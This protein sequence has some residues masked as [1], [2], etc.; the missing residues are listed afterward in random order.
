VKNFKGNNSRFVY[1]Y[2]L[3]INLAKFNSG[4]AVPTLNRNLIKNYRVAKISIEKQ[5]K[6]AAIL[7][8]YDDYI[9]NNL[10][11]IKLLE[12]S[13]QMIYQEWFVKFRFPGYE[14]KKF[15]NGIPEK[16]EKK[17]VDSI[18][19]TI[20][21]RPK[22]HASEYLSTG[23]YP[24][25]DQG[26]SVI[27]GYTNLEEAIY[28]DPLPLIVFGDHTR[29]LKYINFP[30]ACGADGTQLIYPAD[31]RI[32]LGFLYHSLLEIDLSNYAYARHFK[33]LKQESI[34]LPDNLQIVEYFE[35]ITNPIYDKIY[36]LHKLNSKLK[37]A[38]DLLLPK[39]MTGE[40]E[41]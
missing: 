15:V 27:A 24:V 32:G 12:D 11:R 20:K 30:F 2:L 25:I 40:I 41:V 28:A 19:L 10:K 23:D 13:A 36:I 18:L 35:K 34:L 16:W 22:I 14:N 29:R 17:T 1:Y 3:T 39:L 9:E 8:A 26:D 38:R 5:I 37:Q 33:F 7:S 4:G 31:K 21:R 6:I